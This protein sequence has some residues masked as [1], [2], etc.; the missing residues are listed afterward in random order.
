MTQPTRAAEE[1]FSRF[2]NVDGCLRKYITFYL[3]ESEVGDYVAE[4]LPKVG[5]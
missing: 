5:Y 2:F 1:Q 4:S 3:A